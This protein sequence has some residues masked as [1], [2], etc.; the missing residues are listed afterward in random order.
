M[1]KIETV[2]VLISTTANWDVRKPQEMEQQPH[3]L[4]LQFVCYITLSC[5]S[6]LCCNASLGCVQWY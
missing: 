3:M 1:I 6:K 2:T 5:V 4:F